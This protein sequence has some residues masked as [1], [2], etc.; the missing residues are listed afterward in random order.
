M[1]DHKR[2]MRRA[3]ALAQKAWGHTSPNPM[4]GAVLVKGDTVIAEGYHERAGMPH[5][6]A[7]ALALAGPKAKGATLYVTLEPCCHTNKRTPPCARAII[8]AGGKHV[9]A[10]MSDPNPS[11]SGKGFAALR[12]AGIKVTEGVLEPQARE[13]NEAYIKHI[14]TGRPFV[15]LKAAMTLD[16]K[17]ATPDGQ[18]KW[19]TGEAARR[20]VHRVRAGVDAIITAI[21]TVKADDPQMTARH[22]GAKSP[23]RVVID[24]QLEIPEEAKI[25]HCP[26]ETVIVTKVTEGAKFERVVTIPGVRVLAYS[27]RLDMRWLVDE[28]RAGFGVTSVLIEGGSSLNAHA[29]EDRVVDKVMFFIAPKVIGSRQSVPV[30]GG[31]AFRQIDAAHMI[32]DM[33]IRRFGQ[34]ILITGR[35]ISE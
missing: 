2:H 29:F 16:G 30:V 13:L 12:Q 3:L 23:M 5:A 32:E 35:V 28:L 6:E 14:T 26:P 20:H 9:V 11:V 24:P 15:I 33:K 22:K 10:A 1:D 18:S 7:V 21:G 25:L 31:E 34:D 19:I 27:G 4:V 17:I 8:D